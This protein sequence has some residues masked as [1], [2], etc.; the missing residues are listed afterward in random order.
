MAIRKNI[1]EGLSVLLAASCACS[2]DS[3]A[4]STSSSSSSSSST[5]A[6]QDASTSST[7]EPDDTSTTTIPDPLPDVP[8]EPPNPRALSLSLGGTS[9]CATFDDG[10]LR[11]WGGGSIGTREED[12]P[13]HAFGAP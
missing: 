11:C 10:E 8:A 7:T 3:S 13:A 9:S 5:T 2:P 6:P 4:V 1:F 12:M